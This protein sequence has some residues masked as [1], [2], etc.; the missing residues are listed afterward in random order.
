[1]SLNVCQMCA[2]NVKNVTNLF[3]HMKELTETNI[4][5]S[6]NRYFRD[7]RGQKTSRYWPKSITIYIPLE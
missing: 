4:R 2:R 5:E 1:M 3:L 7:F 6:K